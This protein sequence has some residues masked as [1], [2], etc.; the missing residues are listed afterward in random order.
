MRVHHQPAY[1]LLSRP[2]SESSWIVEVF[3]PEYGRLSLM[4]KGARRIKSKLK[5]VLLPFQPLLISWTGK[6]EV[7]TLTSAE[8]DQEKY[9]FAAHELVGDALVC[10]FYCNELMVNL[11]HRHD[12]HPGLYDRYHHTI[13]SLNNP[14][15]SA[16]L[17][18]SLRDF[19]KAVIRETGYEVSFEFE[20][21]GRTK[22][23]RDGYYYFQP[24]QGFIRV[25]NAKQTNIIQGRIIQA[26]ALNEH[27]LSVQDLSQSKLLMRDIL[28]QVLGSKKI[29]S[30]TLFFPKVQYKV[31]Q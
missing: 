8:I 22:I 21:D 24:S 15:Q 7:P 3:S 28:T 11:L 10:G 23:E 26:M 30:R 25:V 4:A 18:Y 20:A 1:V 27:E 29:V 14:E 17:A 19:E 9:D 16:N 2:Y 13:M 31:Q 12:P 6:G 5:G